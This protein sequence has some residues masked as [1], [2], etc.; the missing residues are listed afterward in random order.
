MSTHPELE[1]SVLTG[2]KPPLLP[3]DNLRIIVYHRGDGDDS[4]DDD[5]QY[6]I[7]SC[8]SWHP[9]TAIG[10]GCRASCPC[11]SEDDEDDVHHAYFEKL[12]GNGKDEEAG[13]SDPSKSKK[14]RREAAIKQL[15]AATKEE[16]DGEIEDA[17][18][19]PNGKRKKGKAKAAAKD[20]EESEEDEESDDDDKVFEE[21]LVC[22]L[23]SERVRTVASLSRAKA[24][25]LSSVGQ[26]W[27]VG[28]LVSDLVFSMSSEHQTLLKETNTKIN[29]NVHQFRLL[30]KQTPDR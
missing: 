25:T 8:K 15:L 3:F 9:A 11:V 28:S 16:L 14:A 12:L 29:T 13:P 6:H 27:G 1:D 7:C 19:K 22:T 17:D 20:K 23:D 21:S 10:R 24:L 2:E 18:A 5:E 4:S 26:R 30:A